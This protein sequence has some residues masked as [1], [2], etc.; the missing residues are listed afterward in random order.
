[1][2]KVYSMCELPN[3]RTWDMREAEAIATLYCHAGKRRETFAVEL[4]RMDVPTGTDKT[5]WRFVLVTV[6]DGE[7]LE[8]SLN[9]RIICLMPMLFHQGSEGRRI[10]IPS[11][12][13]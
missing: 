5:A 7:S 12:E 6:R 2:R 1:M 3:N 10:R 8:S 4:Q 13:E 11:D 9:K